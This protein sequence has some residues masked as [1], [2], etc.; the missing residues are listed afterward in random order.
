MGIVPIALFAGNCRVLTECSGR[1]QIPRPQTWNSVL[2]PVGYRARMKAN[3]YNKPGL[4][5][6]GTAGHAAMGAAE[7]KTSGSGSCGG[8]IGHTAASTRSAQLLQWRQGL[9]KDRHA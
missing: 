2:L 9:G 7:F 8:W 3:Q 4:D 5:S 6:L 1:V